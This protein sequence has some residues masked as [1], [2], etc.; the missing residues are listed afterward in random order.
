M[1]CYRL[2]L[3]PAVCYVRPVVVH[4]AVE[5]LADLTYILLPTAFALVEIDTVGCFE[6]GCCFHFVLTSGTVARS[7]VVECSDA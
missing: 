2:L 6:S 3:G 1:C 4:P 7:D 5:Y